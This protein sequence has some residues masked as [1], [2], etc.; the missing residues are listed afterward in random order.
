MTRRPRRAA[1]RAP[2]PL[3]GLLVLAALV[4]LAPAHAVT[5]TE[6]MLRAHA[7]A[8]HPWR[9]AAANLSGTCG[10]TYQSEYT[11]GDQM[12]LPYDWGGYLSLFDFDQ[13]IAQGYAAGSPAAD[14]VLDCNIGVD[15]SGYVS[16]CWGVSKHGTWDLEDISTTINQADLLPGDV[17][18]KAG[19]H[20]VLFERK[21]A[22]GDPV[23]YEASPPNVHVNTVGGW[24]YVS[25]YTP[26][27][28]TGITGTAVGNPAG[29]VDNPIVISS[30]PYTDSRDTRQSASDV[31]DGC[32]AS[33]TKKESGP[34]YIYKVTFT[35]PGTLTATITDDADTDVDIHLYTSLNT[36]DCT[37]RND[38]TIGVPVDCGTY[39]L[40]ADTFV[41]S[42]GTEYAG[43]YT[44]N[45]TFAPSGTVCGGGPPGYD[46]TGAPGD[47]C[48]YPGHESLPFCNLN[49]GGEVCVYST[50]PALSFCSHACATAGDC[51]DFQGGCCGQLGS[52]ERYCFVSALCATANDAGV[53]DGGIT[54]QDAGIQSDGAPPDGWTPQADAA[55]QRDGPAP[56]SGWPQD[57]AAPQRD[58]P[59]P[60]GGWPQDDAG[61]TGDAG[62]GDGGGGCGCR[63][64]AGGGAT[65]ATLAALGLALGRVAGRRRRDP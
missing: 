1:R 55:P 51:S 25:G 56:D 33:P 64:A 3:A 23:F 61:P 46:F 19:Y 50:S 17:M 31:L 35:Q 30:F 22:G 8:T 29:T 63:T 53:V 13:K 32:A 26:R 52:G 38:T 11:V 43:P 12:G 54:P 62:D 24:S 57:D 14:P 10:G 2:K 36:N 45:V 37:A 20:V 44:L 40:V 28:Y 59:E 6:V 41:S 15:C 34:E 18:N 65:L 60:D 16:L 4:A 42:G 48:A 27:R 39:Y 7:Y 5:R 49:L 21:L 58:G 9:C 47:A